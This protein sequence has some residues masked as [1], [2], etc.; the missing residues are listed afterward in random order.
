MTAQEP[1]LKE[2]H[3][4]REAA[5]KTFQWRFPESATG[6]QRKEAHVVGKVILRMRLRAA[7]AFWSSSVQQQV[8][9]DAT[10]MTERVQVLTLKELKV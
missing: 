6:A 7:K 9:A 3:L 1:T 2:Q 10:K 8:L 4:P 5:G